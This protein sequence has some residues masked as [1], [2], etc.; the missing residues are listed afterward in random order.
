MVCLNVVWM[1]LF[2][3][4]LKLLCL[5]IF[6]WCFFALCLRDTLF[7]VVWLYVVMVVVLV[8][9]CSFGLLCWV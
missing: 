6:V 2:C 9:V 3:L 1:C 4:V 5:G 7:W 8:A